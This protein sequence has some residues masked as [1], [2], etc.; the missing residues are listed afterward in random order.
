MPQTLEELLQDPLESVKH[1]ERHTLDSL[2]VLRNDSVALLVPG[3][4]C[5]RAIKQL[6][7]IGIVPLA[8]TD[9]HSSG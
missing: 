9:K 6:K 4:L 2:L 8:V 3:G 1:R 5:K 7:S